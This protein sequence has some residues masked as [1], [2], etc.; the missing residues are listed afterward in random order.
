MVYRNKNIPVYDKE[1]RVVREGAEV[2]EM[3]KEES[4]QYVCNR[5]SLNHYE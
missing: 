5:G 1:F 3:I 4:G 2:Q